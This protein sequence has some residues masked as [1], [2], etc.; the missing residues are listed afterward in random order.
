MLVKPQFELQPGQIGVRARTGAVQT[1]REDADD[2]VGLHRA[3]LVR[4]TNG[5]GNQFIHAQKV[6]HVAG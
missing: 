3:G 4:S 1:W 5:D 2:S 6:E